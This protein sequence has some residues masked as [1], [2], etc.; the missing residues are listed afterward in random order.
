MAFL[1]IW[2]FRNI[3]CTKQHP[4]DF[5]TGLPQFCFVVI[6]EL[7]LNSRNGNHFVG[8][9]IVRRCIT[10][11]REQ[12]IMP[13]LQ[14]WKVHMQV[15]MD[16]LIRVYNG[17]FTVPTRIRT[18]NPVATLYCTVTVPITWTQTLDSN[19]DQDPQSL[20]HPFLGWISVPGSGLESVSSNVNKPLREI[21]LKIH[22][23][24]RL[25]VD[26]SNLT[27]PSKKLYHLNCFRF[28]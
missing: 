19:L 6:L 18:P 17:L 9:R 11:R 3:R 8:H 7:M 2:A 5:P 27:Y 16:I 25:S 21:P 15:P 23:Y 13:P 1:L 10:S 12:M 14:P 28:R 22:Q 4:L 20:L 26:L 24:I